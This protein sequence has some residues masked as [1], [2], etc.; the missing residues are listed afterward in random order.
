MFE[1]RAIMNWTSLSSSLRSSSSAVRVGRE[2]ARNEDGCCEARR[3]GRKA[4][5]GRKME[6]VL[7]DIAVASEKI[8]TKSMLIRE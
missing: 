5:G 3:E 7:V 2:S 6:E 8:V 1:A 4:G